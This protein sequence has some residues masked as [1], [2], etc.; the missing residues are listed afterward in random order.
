[1]GLIYVNGKIN[2][3]SVKI[4]IDTG[5]E[6]SMIQEDLIEKCE[7]QNNLIKI[8]KLTL[9]NA[10]GR[11]ICE[12][13]QSVATKIDIGNTAIET[14]LLIIKNLKN[15]MV[16]G[17]DELHRMEA[18]INYQEK[19]FKIQ[20][21]SVKF[22]ECV[23]EEEN[24][25]GN[26]EEDSENELCM[27]QSN[28]IKMVNKK[29]EYGDL[30][31]IK[32]KEEYEN[33]IKQLLMKYEGLIMKEN[34][35][36]S[37][38]IHKLEVK[39]IENFRA[40]NYPIPYKY[41]EQVNREIQDML[42]KNIIERSNTRFIN[43]LVIVRKTNGEL[44][45]C[46]DARI[47]N[48][49]TVPQYE[50]PMSIDAI[51]G[52]ITEANWFTKMDLK[53]SFWLIPLDVNSRKY[54]GFSVNGVIYQFSVVPFGL[55]SACSALVKALHQVLDKYE[56]FVVH[57]IDDILIFSKTE[58]EHMEHIQMVLK[59]LDEAGLKINLDKCQFYQKEVLFLGYKLTRNGIEMDE[60]RIQSIMDYKRPSN[61]RTLRGFLG[62]V[63]YFKRIIPDISQKTLTFMELLRKGV[64]W[65][66]NQEREKAFIELKNIF[67]ENLRIYHPRYD[68]PFLLRTDAS[69]DKFAGVLLQQFEG[70]EVPI[71]FVSRITKKYE[72]NYNATELELAS[73]IFCI[74]K[75]RFYLLG[76]K[77]YIETDHAAL[78]TIMNN[79]YANNRIHRW[80]LLLQEYDFE[81]RHIPGKSNM[82]DALTRE[83]GKLER[84]NRKFR[85]GMNIIKDEKGL[86]S[87]QEIKQ[88]QK[89]LEEREKSRSVYKNNILIKRTGEK[90]LYVV[91]K[92][93]GRKLLVDIHRKYGHIGSR[94]TLLVFRENYIS[95]GDAAV[96]KQITRTCQICQ[97]NKG[98][99]KMN[100][101]VVKSITAEN[102]L[103]IVAM[104][105]LSELVPTP[106]GN[107]HI[108]VLVDIFSKY[109]K[110]YPCKRTNYEEITRHM[111]NYFER[112]GK[113]KACILDNAT[114]FQSERFKTFCHK[115]NIKLNFTSIR[116]PSAN[117]AER[118]IQEVIKFLRIACERDHTMWE[119]KLKDVEIF[120]NQVPNSNT[121][122]CPIFLLEGKTP[123]RKW[124]IQNMHTLEEIREEVRKRCKKK[125]NK[126][127]KK[128][129][130]LVKKKVKFK[131]GDLVLVRKL[132][133]A[134]R[135]NQQCAKLQEKYEGPY[136]IVTENPK[137]SYLLQ[138]PET[139]ATR[140]VFNIQDIQ[141]Y[142]K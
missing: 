59:E 50:S 105:F 138:H 91:T 122:E 115:N 25:K 82:I 34:R 130:R 114:Y 100:R 47:I 13:N 64:R 97:I 140:G 108:L 103:D 92:I 93:L 53:H 19:N 77:F 2:N 29:E 35:I 12:T 126:Y 63:N 132:R 87:L 96:A 127:V 83:D 52:R 38:Y 116:H 137:N 9:L 128:Q 4:L 109:V 107:K 104:D 142:M 78:T 80:L 120:M 102:C 134:N 3:E 111:K 125:A 39:N 10:N 42:N 22:V 110:L 60:G 17:T 98:R 24:K 131:Q 27:K 40:K 86:Y 81:I 1:M 5:S 129:Q 28:Y 121:E 15:E 18:E 54:T 68:L 7:L 21:D 23:C 33:N 31:K 44:R 89:R 117:P 66:W 36:A 90:E 85:V 123:E 84:E 76:A 113:P 20:N 48:K 57:Y 56:N 139:E 46:L 45:L 65:N 141:K 72:K 118:Y 69:M 51:L 71:Y 62:L 14:Q 37:N 135:E 58:K 26:V 73:I 11:K 124:K 6:V 43:P 95:K 32:C 70:N 101:N 61:L 55:Q 16:L 94:K 74:T 106:N 88:D 49:C 136:M 79:R 133:V 67:Q 99:N 8:P 112:M 41:K 119:E 75:L 30:K